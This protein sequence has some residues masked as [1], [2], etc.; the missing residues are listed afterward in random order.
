M[1]IV[2]HLTLKSMKKNDASIFRRNPDNLDLFTAD[3]YWSEVKNELEWYWSTTNS[4]F[5]ITTKQLYSIQTNSFVSQL[6]V[7]NLIETLLNI[8]EETTLLY[9][10]PSSKETKITLIYSQLTCFEVKNK[11]N[12]L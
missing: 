6:H 5:R 3:M 8:I 9:V 4:I 1:V 10:H 7:N 12:F 2:M 11:L